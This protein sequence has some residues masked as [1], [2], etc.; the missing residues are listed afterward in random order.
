[1]T[2]VFEPAASSAG[3]I[4][5]AKSIGRPTLQETGG[6]LWVLVWL[7]GDP[8]L[9]AEPGFHGRPPQRGDTAAIF[10]WHASDHL[11]KILKRQ[12]SIRDTFPNPAAKAEFT[13]PRPK[14][15]RFEK[16]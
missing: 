16:L 10:L 14:S 11:P 2:P 5:A 1:L 15:N 12:A 6:H 4:G 9:A 13:V 3:F 7:N 8:S